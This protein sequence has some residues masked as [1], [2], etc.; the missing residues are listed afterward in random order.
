LLGSHNHAKL[1]ITLNAIYSNIGIRG[2]KNRANSP[3][4]LYSSDI[5][6][7][8]RHDTDITDLAECL[9]A[10]KAHNVAHASR[11]IADLSGCRHARDR[12]IGRPSYEDGAN[13][14]RCLNA[15]GGY[16]RF[17]GGLRGANGT[18]CRY[19]CDNSNYVS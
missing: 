6:I 17:T 16:V 13:I 5:D 11:S 8:I 14:A 15:S 3:G 10:N 19:S 9:N 2:D 7:G 18:R 12:C 1:G 4:G